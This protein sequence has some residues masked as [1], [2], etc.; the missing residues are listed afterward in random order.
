MPKLTRILIIDDMEAN[1]YTFSRIL[2]K[3][4]YEH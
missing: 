4:G 3:A 2:R 1:R